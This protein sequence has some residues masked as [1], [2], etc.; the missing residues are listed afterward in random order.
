M[1]P[2][3]RRRGLPLAVAAGFSAA[4]FL[5][6]LASVGRGAFV[7]LGGVAALALMLARLGDRRTAAYGIATL[8]TMPLFFVEARVTPA[9]I[10]AMA[11]DAAAFAGLSLLL[12]DQRRLGER[13]RWIALRGASVALAGVGLVAGGL[14][15]GA[16]FG[17]AIPVLG[18]GLAYLVTPRP[19]TA[20]WARDILGVVSL[21]AGVVAA[22][23]G[24]PKDLLGAQ[25]ASFDAVLHR[26]GHAL[27]P[28]SGLLPLAFVALVSSSRP[29]VS[30]SRGDGLR[31]ASLGV[32]V[33]AFAAHGFGPPAEFVPFIAPAPLAAMV[34][35]ALRE[36]D[37]TEAG[38]AG[39][40][41]ADP[42][43]ARAA[44]IVAAILVIV[45]AHDL[46]TEPARAL[47]A[48]VAPRPGAA[49]GPG[50]P[51]LRV[52]EFSF[53]GVLGLVGFEGARDLSE[54][55][56]LLVGSSR[57]LLEVWRGHLAT[58]MIA[59]EASLV[60]LSLSVALGSSR[61]TANESVRQVARFGFWAFPLSVLAVTSVPIL[62][63]TG[64]HAV[65][66]LA[67]LSRGETI[68]AA[69]ACA[70]ALLAFGYY[71]A[72]LGASLHGR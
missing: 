69:G 20:A 27:F 56:A 46:Q 64:F 63:A 7:A 3:V 19:K 25:H 61:L 48:I 60:S 24:A 66:R 21:V 28:W 31:A 52:A 71:P 67:R 41:L 10:S 51:W 49:V 57:A 22:V 8:S 30:G 39:A 11:A 38:S 58:A 43:A 12:F 44:A 35:L 62:L 14:T 18:A 15:R 33:V 16:Y 34:A 4:L 13:A 68:A 59:V 1:S 32:I 40:G 17:I 65:R 42:L 72:L 54:L 53:A 29:V 36:I 9:D 50:S 55:R 2:R 6:P 23:V 47:A 37:R 5:L 26:L 70:G 45:L